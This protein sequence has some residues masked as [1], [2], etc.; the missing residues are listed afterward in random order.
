MEVFHTFSYVRK[1]IKLVPA[2]FSNAYLK[3]T[4][5]AT[6]SIIYNKSIFPNLTINN[7]SSSKDYFLKNI[8]QKREL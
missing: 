5:A 2:Q 7:E 3:S 6:S 1:V 4:Q 8:I